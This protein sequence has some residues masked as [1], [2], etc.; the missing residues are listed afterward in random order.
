MFYFFFI[1][2]VIVAVLSKIIGC[3]LPATFF[4]KDRKKGLQ[5]GYGMISR[6]EVGLI[7][8]G[9]AISAGAIQQDVYSAILGMIIITTIIAPLLLRK[10][11]DK[12]AVEAGET[13]CTW[14]RSDPPDFI[15]TYPLPDEK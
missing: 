13:V 8:A 11:Y 12:E 15:P 2:L 14:D 10:S 7:V 4:L 5:V 1:A 9:V 6:G 3:G